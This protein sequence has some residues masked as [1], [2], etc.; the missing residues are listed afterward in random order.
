MLQHLVK[1][2]LFILLACPLVLF[3]QDRQ[4]NKG[5]GLLPHFNYGVNWTGGDLA[6]RFGQHFN[7]GA[8]IDLITPKSNLLFGLHAQFIFGQKVRQDVLAPIRTSDGLI[9][10]NDKSIAD[11]QLR[12]RG[13]YVGGSIGKI[14][15]LSET[16]DR[17]GI[18]VQ[19]GLG[20]WQHKIRIQE[21]P[22]RSVPQVEGDFK[23]GYDRLTNG[24]ALTNFIGYQLLSSDRSINFYVGLEN[25]LGFTQNRRDINFDTQMADTENRIDYTFGVKVGWIVPI[26]FGKA[27]NEIYY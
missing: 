18:K 10:G 22:S 15:S 12:Q 8:G 25:M 11:I 6:D 17:S 1:I 20:L 9:F 14:F 3:G 19:F 24:L 2:F 21:D 7:F 4:A 26:Y 13:F 23:K 16:N 5:T 27:A